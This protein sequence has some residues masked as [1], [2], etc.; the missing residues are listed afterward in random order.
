MEW[1]RGNHT[2]V[3]LFICFICTCNILLHLLKCKTRFIL[4][5]WHF[6]WWGVLSSCMK[7]QTRSL[8]TDHTEPNQ[9]M[10]CPTV[11]WDLHSSEI[12]NSLEWHLLT[13]DSGWPTGPIFKGQNIQKAKHNKTQVNWH[14]LC[15]STNFVKQY[16]FS[17]A[18]SGSFFRQ[19]TWWTT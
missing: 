14:S 19:R 3:S 2:N 15:L 10:H 7:C 12:S 6:N 18:S 8:W 11:L 17:K 16:S 1:V 5:S 13:D 4:R 9:D